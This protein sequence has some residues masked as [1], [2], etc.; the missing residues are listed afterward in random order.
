MNEE[1]PN[2]PA[3]EAVAGGPPAEGETT[4]QTKPE[5][6]G[7]T[8]PATEEAELPQ[9]STGDFV[10][11]WETVVA[12]LKAGKVTGNGKEI[13]ADRLKVFRNGV[14]LAVGS[15]EQRKANINK[16][17]KAGGY[18]ELSAMPRASTAKFDPK[19]A[20]ALVQAAKA[21]HAP[22]APPSA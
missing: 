5:G 1:T 8:T 19:A 13:V 6:E 20:A 11:T 15:V 9:I 16:R 21:K 3:N 7:Q 2:V 4:E 17:L 14:P 18:D 12:E 22:A 10:E